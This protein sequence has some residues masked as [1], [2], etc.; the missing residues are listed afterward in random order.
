MS[1]SY[2]GLS[3]SS[4]L[5]LVTLYRNISEM[6]TLYLLKEICFI[7]EMMLISFSCTNYFNSYN[8]S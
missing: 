1:I 2:E 7:F 6:H 3:E 4:D 8:L 5:C